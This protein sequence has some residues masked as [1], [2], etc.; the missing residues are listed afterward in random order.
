MSSI[1]DI[2]QRMKT[3]AAESASGSVTDDQRSY[4][5]SEFSQL[6]QEVGTVASGTRF[7][8][9]SLLAGSTYSGGTSFLVGTSVSD[10]IKVTI[11]NADASS[12]SISSLDVSSASGAS[13]AMTKL[14]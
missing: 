11:H 12:L 10:T 6:I 14:D 5:N 9:N 8:G 2:L 7:D 1:S 4:I 3:L 13:S